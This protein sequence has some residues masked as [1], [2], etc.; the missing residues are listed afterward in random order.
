MIVTCLPKV[1]GYNVL[2]FYVSIILFSCTSDLKDLRPAGF[3]PSQENIAKGKIYIER[4]AGAHGWNSIDSLALL[5]VKYTDDWSMAGF[6]ISF[7]NPWPEDVQRLEHRIA[8]DHFK[9]SRVE[10]LSGEKR[11]EIWGIKNGKAYKTIDGKSLATDEF[12]IRFFLSV[13]EYFIQLPKYAKEVPMVTYLGDSSYSNKNYHL[14]LG[15]WDSWEPREDYDQYIY[16]IDQDGYKLERL[17]YTTRDIGK[18]AGGVTHFKDYRQVGPL[19]IPFI[20]EVYKWPG[21]AEVIHKFLL[22]SVTLHS[23]NDIQALYPDF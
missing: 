5:Q 6:I 2:F 13:F 20:H 7:L 4:M 15:T 9:T 11:G 21:N 19:T 8:Y 10:L 16:W 17:Q 3:N 14:V 1:F 23:D 22:E 18:G 12:G